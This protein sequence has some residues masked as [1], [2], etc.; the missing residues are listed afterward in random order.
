[1]QSHNFKELKFF[2]QKYWWHVGRRFI[3]EIILSKFYSKNNIPERKILEVGCGTGGNGRVLSQF[4]ELVGLDNSA[5]ALNLASGQGFSKLV[6]G[7][8]ANLPFGNGEF[9][10]VAMLDVL[11]HIDDTKSVLSE[12]H[13]ALVAKGGLLLTVPAYQWL[14]SGHDEALGHKRR[15]RIDRLT[16][17]IAAVGFDV[18]SKSYIITFLFPAMAAYRITEKIFRHKQEESYV[19]FPEYIN[20]F[21][22]FLLKIE[23]WLLKSGIR[24]PFGTSIIVFARKKA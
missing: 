11:E 3:I 17:E 2:E 8:A 21:F 20:A 22:I 4:G 18:V 1:M 15:Y 16:T 13:R 7:Q 12:C 10:L 14:W 5:E 24:F 6:L 19:I 23:G 9:D